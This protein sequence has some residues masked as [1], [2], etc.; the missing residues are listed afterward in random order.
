VART[1]PGRIKAEGEAVGRAFL[2]ALEAGLPADSEAAMDAAEA[3]RLQIDRAFCPCSHEMQK[4]LAAMYVADAR[5]TATYEA[6]APGMA[7]YVHDAIIANAA[8]HG[9]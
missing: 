3:H 6:Q 8:R 4:G 1:H 9:A 5:F 2:A 7:H